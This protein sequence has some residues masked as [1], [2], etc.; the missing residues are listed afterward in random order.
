M[1]IFNVLKLKSL[2]AELVSGRQRAPVIRQMGQSSPEDHLGVSEGLAR[3]QRAPR[4]GLC[5]Q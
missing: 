3:Q 2:P 1:A 4:R 5:S